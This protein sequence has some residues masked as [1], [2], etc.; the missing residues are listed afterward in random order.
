MD[1]IFSRTSV[2][3]YLDKPIEDAKV[4]ALLRAG[5]A[6]PSAHNQQPWEFWVVV[7]PDARQRLSTCTP[8]TGPAGR[9]PIDLVLCSRN[10][11]LSAPEYAQI[12]LAIATEN[13][14]LEATRQGLGT[15]M[16]GIAP[17]TDRMDAVRRAINLP[18][19]VDAFCIV[20]VGYPDP[21]HTHE[22]QDRFDTSRVHGV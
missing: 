8:Y 10:Q 7:N 18:A 13:V 14:M 15:C 3:H 22:Q 9:A 4:E 1:A 6:A 20:S 11:N 12:D 2:R 19:G 21:A 16:M 17:G 5:M